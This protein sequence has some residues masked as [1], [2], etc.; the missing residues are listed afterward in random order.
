MPELP[1][2]E[3]TLRG[4][5]P[6]LEGQTLT[7]VEIRAPQL[8]QPTPAASL[9]E[10][11]TLS[12]LRRRNKYIFMDTDDGH[13]LILHLGMSGRLTITDSAQPLLKHDHVIFRTANGTEVRLH[14]PR[15]FG[16]LL[17]TPTA[18]L[19][20]HPLVHAIGPEPLTEA[21][22]AA[23]LHASLKTKAIPIKV[24]LMDGKIVAGVG[25]IYASESLFHAGL[26]PHT[27]AK[28]LT[29]KQCEKLITSVRITLNAAIAAGGSSLRDFAH[30]NG[31]LGYFQHTF[32]VYG[33]KGHPCHVCQ[34]PIQAEVLAQRSTF[35]CPVCQ[36]APKT[37]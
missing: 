29:L 12:N 15:R 10:G 33:R 3:T 7:H 31:Q 30:S 9:I 16:L 2:V 24:A 13:T 37:K 21:F 34:T 32:N 19:Q 36:P 4:L 28:S 8:R 22:S 25:N 6:H 27:P 17:R 14:D 5:L 35:W 20:N 26:N 23:V 18:T 11:R 1:E